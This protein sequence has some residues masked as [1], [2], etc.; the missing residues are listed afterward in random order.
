M[1]PAYAHARFRAQLPGGEFASLPE[2]FFIIT[3]WNPDGLSQEDALNQQ[4]AAELRALVQKAD[5]DHFQVTGYDTQSTHFE[6]GLG[7]VTTLDKALALGRHFRQE[8]IFRVHRGQVSLHDCTPGAAPQPLRTWTAMADPE[9][10][11]Q[12]HFRGPMP[13]LE[14]LAN[15]TAFFCSTVC[16]GE[17]I[18]EAY[19]WARQQCDEGTTIISGFHT[20]VEKDVHAILA[21][22]GATIIH[23]PARDLPT[24][25]DKGLEKAIAE[26][27]LLVLSPFPFGGPARATRASCSERNRFIARVA[28]ASYIPHVS[29]TSSLATDLNL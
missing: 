6:E 1:N 25:P 29:S 28:A 23:V 26:N 18:L 4:A 3:A 20:P 24:R 7:I 21:R 5:Q 27:R 9:A 14:N 11:P 19:Q 17:K 8:A 10:H 22:R 15:A 2:T 12:L 13:L 16:P